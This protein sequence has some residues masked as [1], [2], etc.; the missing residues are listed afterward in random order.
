MAP[1]QTDGYD[2]QTSTVSVGIWLALLLD[3][4]I[5]ITIPEKIAALHSII[6]V[7]TVELGTMGAKE[8]CPGRSNVGRDSPQQESA[9]N[10]T[11][12]RPQTASDSEEHTV[13]SQV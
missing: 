8:K 3:I 7:D 5:I 10:D 2:P 12:W 4:T 9:E 6:V 11:W 1:I 13:S